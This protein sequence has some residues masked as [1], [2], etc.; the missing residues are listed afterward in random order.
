MRFAL[1]AGETTDGTQKNYSVHLTGALSDE[2]R[3]TMYI[4]EFICGIAATLIFEGI[5]L[6]I[7]GLSSGKKGEK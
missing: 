4:P 7:W 6:I 1:R 3:K 5:A 2:R